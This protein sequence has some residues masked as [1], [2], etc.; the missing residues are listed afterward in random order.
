MRSGSCDAKR[1]TPVSSGGDSVTM[2]NK[3]THPCKDDPVATAPPSSG[4]EFEKR[5]RP[6]G[7]TC[8]GPTW[9]EAPSFYDLDRLDRLDRLDCLTAEE[10]RRAGSLPVARGRRSHSATGESSPD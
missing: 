4:R 1:A 10:R 9:Q 5:P 8:G 2:E 6:T 3:G 7:A